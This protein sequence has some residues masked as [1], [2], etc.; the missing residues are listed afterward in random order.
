[1]TFILILTACS[2]GVANSPDEFLNRE[3]PRVA[4]ASQSRH[5]D[6]YRL[7]VEDVLDVIFR[8]GQFEMGAYRLQIQDRIEI[9]F[10]TMPD[11]NMQQR[12]RTDGKISLPYIDDIPIRG[13]TVEEATRTLR[14]AYQSVL[15]F[16]DV[17]LILTESMARIREL[18][19]TIASDNA[20]RSKSLQ[21]RPDGF[22]TFP[23]I[24]GVR[25]AGRTLAHLS[26][27]VNMLY[28][29]LVPGLQVD[30]ILKKAADRFF[31]VIGEVNKK[32][33]FKINR[34]ITI[35]E[36]IAL[37]GG[38]TS[39]SRLKDV[40]VAR[41]MEDVVMYDRINLQPP[42]EPKK[43]VM[44]KADDIILLPRRRLT[45]AA[46]IAGE[47]SQVLFFRGSSV[48]FNYRLND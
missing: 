16:P 3:T 37:A 34:P 39:T 19:Q 38:P 41:R 42:H 26:N 4:K 10:P 15:R 40:I 21:V 22:V 30:V 1:L 45:T 31:Y 32:G 25:V 28:E 13:L 17:Y 14:S 29:E 36:A 24:G 20:G 9:R 5:F 33:A 48:G 6:D 18:Q 12:I 43:A 11:H 47:I 46:Q 23:I 27:T 7:G 8:I 44:I 35:Q 2:A